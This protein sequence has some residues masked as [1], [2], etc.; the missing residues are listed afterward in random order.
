[1]RGVR[2]NGD[3]VAFFDKS[4]VTDHSW[5]QLPMHSEEGGL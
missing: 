2:G 4:S 1:M 5:K 3:V